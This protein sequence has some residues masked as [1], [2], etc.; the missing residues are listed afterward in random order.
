MEKDTAQKNTKIASAAL[1][2][3]NNNQKITSEVSQ[4]YHNEITN[5]SNSI[6]KYKRLLN[7]RVCTTVSGASPSNNGETSSGKYVGQNVVSSDKLID[8]AAEA[9][10]YRIQVISLQDFINKE[11]G[12]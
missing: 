7:N 1:K 11:R 5:L 2:V 9:E 4:E 3:C 6:T 10:R 12:R 8:F